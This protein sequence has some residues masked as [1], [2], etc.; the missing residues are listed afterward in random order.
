MPASRTASPSAIATN[1][2]R[3]SGNC[4]KSPAS[5]CWSTIRPAPPT[6]AAA[7]GVI[8]VGALLGMA[9]H[10]DGKG[11]TVLDFPGVAQKNGAVMSHLR[12][13]PKPEDLHA[14][15]IAAGG[16]N[17]VLGCDMVVAAAPAA[18]SPIEP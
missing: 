7:A 8:T 10:L 12:R 6:S 5:P 17:L 1:W 16:A 15:C 4:G 3:C 14:G 18:L 9:A 11:C 13:A 2:T